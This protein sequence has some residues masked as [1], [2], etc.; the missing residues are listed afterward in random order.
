VRGGT[1]H[2]AGE[3][4]ILRSFITCMLHWILFGDQ[5]KEY[6]MGRACRMNG[7]DDKYKINWKT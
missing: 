7:R 2:E 6:E 1:W 3:D 5:I 4:C